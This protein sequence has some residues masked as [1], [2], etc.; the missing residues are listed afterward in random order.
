M[1]GPKSISGVWRGTYF[2]DLAEQR[3]PDGG[4]VGFE[5]RLT[6]TWLQRLFGGFSGTVTDDSMR[7]MSGTGTIHGRHSKTSMRFT[8][9]MPTV[10]FTQNGKSLTL[11]ELLERHG[12]AYQVKRTPHPPILYTG[13]VTNGSKVFGTWLIEESAIRIGPRLALPTLRCS[14]TFTLTR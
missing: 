7:G 4:G 11:P 12:R 14:G 6:Q 13:T 9:Q 8:K 3:P 2:Y 10:Q 1:N 5:L